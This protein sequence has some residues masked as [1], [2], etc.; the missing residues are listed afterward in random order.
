MENN[1]QQAQS[2]PIAQPVD[3]TPAP[4]AVKNTTQELECFT[5]MEKA[6]DQNQILLS[7]PSDTPENTKKALDAIPNISLD[8]TPDGDDWVSTLRASGYAMPVNGWF[9]KTL[10]RPEA[11]YRQGVQSERGT[12]TIAAPKF[13]D[14]GGMKL[15]GER[16]VLRVRAL[17]GMG[18][19]IRIPLWHSGFWVTVKAPSDGEVLELNR[20]LTEEKILLGRITH[21]LAYAN[22]SVVFAGWVMDFVI[23]NIYDTTLKPE[24]Q[25]DL[26]KYISVLDIPLLAWGM[27]CAIWPNGFPYAR[28]VLDQA[29]NQNKVIKE[30]VKIGRLLWVDNSALSPWQISHMANNHSGTMDQAMLERY[31]N[32][33]T[34]G[35]GRRVKLAENLSVM[36][37]VPNLEQYLT[38]GQKWVNGIVSMVDKAFGMDQNEMIRDN[39]IMDQSRATNMRQYVHYVESIEAGDN[40]IDDGETIDKTCDALSSDDDIRA[41]YFKGVREFTEDATVALVAVPAM[42]ND[43]DK[44]LPRF[45]HL[46]PL[47]ALS[48]FFILLVQRI[49]QIQA[50]GG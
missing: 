31:R 41:A 44:T 1:E 36:L 47:D 10:E 14:T 38:S 18:S 26:R 28:A 8:E 30:I 40:T 6:W 32:E 48:T 12:L 37:R 22:H 15:T 20:R 2:E 13:S 24:L 7:L 23:S 4:E 45:P 19:V 3:N 33:F 39:Y 27:A 50:R 11:Q 25:Q 17:T 49:P 43:A 46:L 9:G 16:A 35:K 34:R 29:T 21:G 42:E 5:P